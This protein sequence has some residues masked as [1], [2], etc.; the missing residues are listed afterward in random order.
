MN[1]AV[2]K[3]FDF[4]P[5]EIPDQL[6]FCNPLL[7]FDKS[8]EAP[9]YFASDV[10]WEYEATDTTAYLTRVD[11]DELELFGVADL[12]VDLR[13]RR[14]EGVVVAGTRFS[15]AAQTVGVSLDQNPFVKFTKVLTP[16]CLIAVSSPNMFRELVQHITDISTSLFDSELR[17]SLGRE[18]SQHAKEALFLLRHCG[19]IRP[20]DLAVRQIAAARIANET[21]NYRRLLIKF[22]I[23]LEQTEQQLHERVARYLSGAAFWGNSIPIG[24]A[25]D[26]S[27][28]AKYISMEAMRSANPVELAPLLSWINT[29]FQYRQRLDFLGFKKG[30]NVAVKPLSFTRS[31]ADP[32]QSRETIRESVMYALWHSALDQKLLT[33]QTRRTYFKGIG[34]V[35]EKYPFA[36]TYGRSKSGVTGMQIDFGKYS[37]SVSRNLDTYFGQVVSS[38]VGKY[39]P[40]YPLT[41][42]WPAQGGRGMA[43][44]FVSSVKARNS[45]FRMRGGT[46]PTMGV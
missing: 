10:N 16:P 45:S 30:L 19:F 38:E 34:L 44:A 21:D 31:H 24:L 28:S 42:D 27:V 20:T 2:L 33:A 32:A 22:S 29:N 41:K 37:E 40:L 25:P 7:S 15:A 12:D 46:V 18:L 4:S 1:T 9:I 23:R 13:V 43:I 6:R 8:D 14:G 39:Q 26:V 36:P 35:Q 3:G 11:E 5:E 17:K